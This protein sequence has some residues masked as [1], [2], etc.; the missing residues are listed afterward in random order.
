MLS[1]TCFL[2]NGVYFRS[3]ELKELGDEFQESM[4][5]YESHQ[6]SVVKDIIATAASYCVLLEQVNVILA[7]LDV[8]LR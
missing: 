8:L 6:S 5:S 3:R 7:E 4:Q 1:L 2:Q